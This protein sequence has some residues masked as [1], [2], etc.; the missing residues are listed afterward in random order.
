MRCCSS[1]EMIMFDTD[2]GTDDAI[3]FYLLLEHIN[4]GRTICLSSFGNSSLNVGHRNLVHLS[5]YLGFN[6]RIFAGSSHSLAGYEFDSGGYHGSDG[7]GDVWS[8]GQN[9]C[10]VDSS[11]CEAIKSVEAGSEKYTYIAI[12]PLT[13]LACLLQLDP[14]IVDRID[15]VLVM[16]GGFDRFNRPHHSEFNFHCDP[17]AVKAVLAH[18]L[19]V[20]IFPL[21]MTMRFPL[22]QKDIDALK[23]HNSMHELLEIL[24]FNHDSALRHG[25]DGAIIHDAFPVL[26]M[27]FPDAFTV[28]EKYILSDE[29]GRIFEDSKGVRVTVATSIDQ[30]LLFC[31]LD[32][33]LQR[34]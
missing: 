24:Q 8:L 12:G 27:F 30:S 1:S 26:Y 18:Q 22:F 23:R 14:Q 32:N 34:G 10:N 9:A 6:G 3:A 11:I 4:G 5:E 33:C 13:N 25:L 28:E 2:S 17:M 20:V 31:V 15:K 16:G 21:D 7:L 29:H 19:D